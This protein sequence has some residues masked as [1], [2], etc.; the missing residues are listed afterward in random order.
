MRDIELRIG[1]EILE[2]V[3]S[4]KYEHREIPMIRSKTEFYMKRFDNYYFRNHFGSIKIELH[5]THLNLDDKQR[6]DSLTYGQKYNIQ[7]NP[8]KL[9]PNT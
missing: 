8:L 7:V 6:L 5:E 4:I 3:T 2:G 1:G 9:I